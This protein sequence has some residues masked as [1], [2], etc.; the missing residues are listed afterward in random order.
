MTIFGLFAL[1]SACTTTMVQDGNNSVIV[2]PPNL[3]Q[4]AQINATLA[5]DYASKDMLDRAKDKLLR[6]ESQYKNIDTLDYAWGYY[7]EKMG[8]SDIADDYYQKAININSVDPNAYNFYARFLC[9]NSD[10]YQR[11]NDLFNHS[12]ELKNN[13]QLGESFVLYANCLAKQ[14]QYSLAET[15]FFNAL[16]QGGVNL[17]STYGLASL[18]YDESNY[19]KALTYINAYL[20]ED[21]QSREALMLKLNIAKSLNQ[22]DLAAQTKL[23][24]N[25]LSF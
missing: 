15:M 8:M 18:C 4:A 23:L 16:K 5:I 12:I 6:A 3:K 9:Q 11:A 2:Q 7:Y 24:L 22:K 13:Q 10:N 19:Q 1:L 20:Q 17:S 25:S 21:S 14:E